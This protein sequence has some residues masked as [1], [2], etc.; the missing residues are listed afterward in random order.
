M[1]IALFSDFHPDTLGGAQTALRALSSGLRRAGHR[2]TVF[3][4]PAPV[5]GPG[6]PPDAV[7]TPHAADAAPRPRPEVISDSPAAG[8]HSAPADVV[9]LRAQPFSMA[10]GLPIVLPTRANERTIDAAFA[11]R[12]P[13]DVVHALTT[14]GCGIAAIR[15]ARRYGVPLVQTLQSRDDMVVEKYSPAP[16]LG[17]L[18]MRL[19]HGRYLRGPAVPRSAGAGRTAR[20]A[21]RPLLAHAAAADRVIAPSR[22][23]A[24]RLVRHGV[25]TPIDVVSNGIADELLDG[26]LD[27]GRDARDECAAPAGDPASPAPLRTVWCGRLSAEK[28]PL[29]AIELVRLTRDCGLDVYGAGPLL[30]RARALI[31]R[32]GLG[33][34]VRLHGAVTQAEC[35]RAMRSADLLL[36]TSDCDTQGMVL[37]EAVASTL[38]V[39]YCDPDLTETLPAGGVCAADSSVRA[40][41][42]ALGDLVGDRDRIGVL[43]AE[44]APV[45]DEPRQSRHLGRMVAVYNEARLGREPR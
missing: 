30:D 38:P 31:A 40:M 8:A 45:R 39:L 44:L 22:H 26:A 15:A 34:R 28:R 24:G 11:D 17:A 25:R 7:R 5:L 18:T 43:R 14:Y 10:N 20:L 2:V 35:L 29:E 42:A 13:V 6:N 4:A 9:L 19:V 16:Y 27:P 32:H 23:F 37:L 36:L 3:C 12:A 41:A 21:W 33:D 1:H